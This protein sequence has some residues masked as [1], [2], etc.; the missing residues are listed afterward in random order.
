METRGNVRGSEYQK[1]NY[2]T[3]LMNQG[4]NC[5]ATITVVA[6]TLIYQPPRCSS[7]LSQSGARTYAVGFAGFTSHHCQ[8]PA[9]SKN[10]IWVNGECWY[11]VAHRRGREG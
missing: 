2:V 11:P 10:D 1:G 7:T 3:D 5:F 6:G 8:A 9:S 4:D